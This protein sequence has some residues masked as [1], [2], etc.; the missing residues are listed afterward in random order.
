M[1]LPMSCSENCKKFYV[2]THTPI[3]SSMNST[4]QNYVTGNRILPPDCRSTNYK[5]DSRTPLKY[6][7]CTVAGSEKEIGVWRYKYKYKSHC[8]V[9]QRMC[10][11]LSMKTRE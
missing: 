11:T 10:I 5:G 1:V 8:G 3:L 9:Q 7:V 6:A 2:I 4:R